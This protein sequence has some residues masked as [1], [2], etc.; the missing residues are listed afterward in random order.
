M[1]LDSFN[2]CKNS[3][4]FEIIKICLHWEMKKQWIKMVHICWLINRKWLDINVSMKT[5]KVHTHKLNN[6]KMV[7][8][9]FSYKAQGQLNSIKLANYRR[10]FSTVQVLVGLYWRTPKGYLYPSRSPA[11]DHHWTEE[12]RSHL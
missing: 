2:T 11:A 7:S 8:S 3:I 4:E 1:L 6:L 5:F 12:V 10:L 9:I